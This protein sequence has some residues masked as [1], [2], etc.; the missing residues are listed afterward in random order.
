MPSW[1]I[2]VIYRHNLYVRKTNIYDAKVTLYPVHTVQEAQFFVHIQE[3]ITEQ[4]KIET[5]KS[6]FVSL[7][8]HQLRTPLTALRWTLDMFLKGKLGTVSEKQLSML[9]DASQCAHNMSDTV[10]AMLMLSRLEAGKIHLKMQCIQ[11][12]DFWQK[13]WNNHKA[14]ANTKNIEVIHSCSPQLTICTD[15]TL[16]LE[17]IFLMII[18]SESI[19]NS[20]KTVLLKIIMLLHMV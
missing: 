8:S 4:K 10:G 17:I 14:I 2:I 12:E 18:F 1:T 5:A 19:Y 6:E 9:Q 7:A 13:V 15:A 20:V 3:D 16:L 11:A